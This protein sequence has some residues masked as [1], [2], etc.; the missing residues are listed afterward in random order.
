MVTGGGSTTI[1]GGAAAAINTSVEGNKF[2][3]GGPSARCGGRGVTRLAVRCSGGPT[4]IG[5]GGPY[6]TE[7]GGGG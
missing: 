3:G 7:G 1:G 4:A 6:A 2:I 5:G